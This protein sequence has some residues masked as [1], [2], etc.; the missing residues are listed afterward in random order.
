MF[1]VLLVLL[2]GLLQ[3]PLPWQVVGAGHAVLELPERMGFA[4]VTAGC[5]AARGGAM[6]T[7]E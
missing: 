4:K 5:R 6:L 2:V 3:R 7:A 1:V